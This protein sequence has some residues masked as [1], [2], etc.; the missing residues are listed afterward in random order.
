MV[1]ELKRDQQNTKN[2]ETDLNTYGNSG[3]IHV[4][5]KK[6]EEIWVYSISRNE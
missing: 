1:L 6:M 4:T 3:H 5:L 2:S